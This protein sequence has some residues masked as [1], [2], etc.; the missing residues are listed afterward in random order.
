ME[1]NIPEQPAQSIQTIQETPVQQ[2]ISET[3]PKSGKSK[4]IL[5]AIAI[6]VLIVVGAGSYYL[7]QKSKNI[8]PQISIIKNTPTPTQAPTPT[9]DPTV[10]WKTYTNPEYNYSFKNPTNWQELSDST[11]D[12]AI[13]RLNPVDEKVSSGD[14]WLEVDV[15]KKWYKGSIESTNMEN[16]L[17]EQM[18]MHK[19][20][21]NVSVANQKGIKYIQTPTS[22]SPGNII[23]DF[24]KNG[25]GYSIAILYIKQ[26]DGIG[27]QI[28]STFKFSQ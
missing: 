22:Q 13:F 5:I 10:N 26:N 3:P 21:E 28:L 24:V 17:S 6:I 16:W 2:P 4:F 8:Q 1:P 9:S 19:D 15:L 18:N 14:Y 25:Y 12:K 7:G 20:Y 11:V 27:E 23:Y